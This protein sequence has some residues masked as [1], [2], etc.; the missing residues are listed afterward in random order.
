[1]GEKDEKVEWTDPALANE[2]DIPDVVSKGYITDEEKRR[3]YQSAQHADFMSGDPLF[4]DKEVA[5][6]Q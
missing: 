4:S 6:E 5:T 2:M 1:M 3:A